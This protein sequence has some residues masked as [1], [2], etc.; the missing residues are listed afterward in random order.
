MHTWPEFSTRIRFTTRCRSRVIV[1]CLY[2]IFCLYVVLARFGWVWVPNCLTKQQRVAVWGTDS[3]SK[4]YYTKEKKK[5]AFWGLAWYGGL[6]SHFSQ[7]GVLLKQTVAFLMSHVRWFA[8]TA[9]RFFQFGKTFP[10]MEVNI[11]KTGFL[12]W[13]CKSR[14]Q[15]FFP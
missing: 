11:S 5:K 2:Y 7:W 13:K 1:A 9:N 6:S 8:F 10:E 15:V 3:R 4:S 12:P 14:A